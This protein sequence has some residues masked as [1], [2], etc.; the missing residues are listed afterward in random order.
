MLQVQIAA[1]GKTAAFSKTTSGCFGGSISLGFGKQQ[2]NLPL[3]EEA[4]NYFLST[5][6][7][8]SGK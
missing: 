6:L 3:G 1:K 2:E 7:E 8:S 4:F 5:G